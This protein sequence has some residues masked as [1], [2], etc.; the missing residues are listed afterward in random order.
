MVAISLVAAT[1]ERVAGG[2]TGKPGVGAHEIRFVEPFGVA[3][4]RAGNLYVI[5]YTGNRLIQIES[6][7]LVRNAA[8]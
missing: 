4:D 7:V 2:G 6:A 1:V 5:E 8:L 3:F